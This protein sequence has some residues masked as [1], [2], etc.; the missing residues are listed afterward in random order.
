MWKLS[1]NSVMKKIFGP[2]REEV[3]GHWNKI[4]LIEKLNNF[5]S[6]PN[7]CTVLKGRRIT[8]TEH[9]MGMKRT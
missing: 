1:Q 9:V 5:C 3:T 8:W 2:D 7:K 4:L 6:S